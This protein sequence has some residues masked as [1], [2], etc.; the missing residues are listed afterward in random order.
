M[1]KTMKAAKTKV[2]KGDIVA[3]RFHDHVESDDDSDV[4]EFW[5]YGVVVKDSARCIGIQ[6]W[7]FVNERDELE[8]GKS[9]NVKGYSIVH[10]AILEV[11][12]L[13]RQSTG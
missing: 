6:S 12:R 7:H 5:V 13:G 11:K 9:H 10:A 1:A 4:I 2:R 8:H 3:I